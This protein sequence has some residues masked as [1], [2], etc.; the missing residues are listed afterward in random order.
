MGLDVH[1]CGTYFTDGASRAF[2][3]GQ[4]TTIEPGLYIAPDDETVEAR[5]RGIG[6]RVEDDI[7]VTP[8]GHENLTCMIPK[9]VDDVEA[10][11][12]GAELIARR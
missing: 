10:A 9:E 5:W 12:R 3:P 1:D 8:S 11:C 6:V 4:I 2:Q 7:L